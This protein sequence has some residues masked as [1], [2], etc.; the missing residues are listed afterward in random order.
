VTA[1]RY[2][3]GFDNTIG[4]LPQP[5]A[6]LDSWPV[7]FAERRLIPMADAAARERAISSPLADA[8]V[9]LAARLGDLLP[10]GPPAS[11]IHGDVWSGNVLS[12]GGVIT[13]FLDPAAYYADAEV[14]LAFI[15][16]FST[17]GSR[18]FDAYQRSRPIDPG[19]WATRRDLYNLYPLLVHA[20]LFRGQYVAQL[21][22]TL[23]RFL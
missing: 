13:A 3:L 23:R 20:R 5:N 2:G 17:F 15:T 12:E 11:L 6:W 1:P 19:F 7:F 10:A 22:S 8:V 16:L 18:F 4:P 14:E 9:R 21:D